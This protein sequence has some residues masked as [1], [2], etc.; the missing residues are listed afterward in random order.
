MSKPS[1]KRA[2]DSWPR[3]RR[4][5]SPP[6]GRKKDEVYWARRAIQGFVDE[7]LELLRNAVKLSNGRRLDEC[8]SLGDSIESQHAI[9]E[10][11]YNLKDALEFADGSI[12]SKEDPLN[13]PDW[14]F[15]LRKFRQL[16]P[17]CEI[18]RR[19]LLE[20]LDDKIECAE[21]WHAASDNAGR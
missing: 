16:R 5:P 10:R 15:L 6:K 17:A 11:I 7:C 12:F 8:D 20:R 1:V 2:D 21:N 14:L 3:R 19:P 13:V 4:F 18:E 9:W